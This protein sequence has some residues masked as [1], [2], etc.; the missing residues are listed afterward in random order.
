MFTFPIDMDKI[1]N[2]VE[3]LIFC[4][5]IFKI[6]KTMKYNLLRSKEICYIFIVKNIFVKKINAIK[7]KNIL[8]GVYCNICLL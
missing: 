6:C 5:V 2:L 3:K 1:K 7:C 8:R 4:F